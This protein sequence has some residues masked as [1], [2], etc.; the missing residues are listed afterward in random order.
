MKQIILLVSFLIVCQNTQAQSQQ[1]QLIRIMV[2][3]S[4]FDMTYGINEEITFDIAVYKFGQLVPNAAIFYSYGPEMVDPVQEDSV[5]LVKGNTQLKAGK[6]D[7]PGF[8]RCHVTYSENGITY[9]NSGTAAVA[10]EQIKP[11]AELPA[12]FMDFW[13][14]NLEEASRIPLEPTLTHMPEKSTFHS[15]VFHVSFR[16]ITGHV[17][18]ILTKPR[19]QGKYPAILVVPGAGIRPYNERN[20]NRDVITLQIGIHGIPVN[21]YDSPLYQNLAAGALAN[22]NTNNMEDKDRYY[23][24]RVYVGCVRAVDFIYSLDDFDGKQIGVMGGSQGGALSI[25]TAGL[26]ERIKFLVSYYPALS[27]LTGYLHG[28]AGGWPHL[29]KNTFT[30]QPEKIATS[31]YFDVVNFARRVNVPGLYSFGFNDNVCPPTSIYSALNVIP[32]KKDLSL[33]KDAAHW[34]YPEQSSEGDQW[35]FERLGIKSPQ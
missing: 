34:T 12:D 25:V 21:L 2:S 3:P 18:G 30:N 15:D 16:N 1:G 22:Y 19:K 26:D 28:R 29:F 9:Q 27:D 13:T 7:Q 5:T 8:F 10:P 11:T 4:K 23:F 14:K 24:K 35:M 33:Y 20:T 31:A 32:G 17:Y 6:M